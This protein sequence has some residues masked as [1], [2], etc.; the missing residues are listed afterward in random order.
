MRRGTA[1]LNTSFAFGY[2]T[3]IPSALMIYLR[4]GLIHLS[5]IISDMIVSDLNFICYIMCTVFIRVLSALYLPI[6][7]SY[8]FLSFQWRAH[9]NK[10]PFLL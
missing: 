2:K 4:Y 10:I 9:Q 6:D 5:I 1:K 3:H 8:D 7:Q